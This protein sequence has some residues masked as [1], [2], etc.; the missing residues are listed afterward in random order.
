MF[1]VSGSWVVVAAVALVDARRLTAFD[2]D[3]LA[4]HAAGRR[5]V[6]AERRQHRPAGAGV[7]VDAR[8]RHLP[9][10]DR[11]LAAR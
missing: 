10:C 7:S 9:I 3:R 6:V 4:L 8:H 1:A 11:L 2:V 5:N